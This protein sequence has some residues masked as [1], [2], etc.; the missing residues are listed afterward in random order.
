MA[1]SNSTPG[2]SLNVAVVGATG[3]VGR[4]L[5]A[6]LIARGHRVTAVT[7]HPELVASHPSV[8]TVEA[9]ANDSAQL[10]PVITGH[11]VVVTAIQYAK[12]D[13]A[14]ADLVRQ[15]IEGAALLRHGRKRNPARAG[16]EDT[17]HGHGRLPPGIREI[18]RRRGALLEAAG[19]GRRPGLDLPRSAARNRPG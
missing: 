15:G 9:D 17:R 11:D 16:H 2:P 6:E 7:T 5:I 3:N 12:T 1:E 13:H 10:V 14:P 8:R 19:A 4:P 18:G